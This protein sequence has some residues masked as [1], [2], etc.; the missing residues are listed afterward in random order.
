MCEALLSVSFSKSSMDKMI[1]KKEKIIEKIM[2]LF[3][4]AHLHLKATEAYHMPAPAKQ[5]VHPI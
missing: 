1:K 5:G 4:H 2:K 3:S